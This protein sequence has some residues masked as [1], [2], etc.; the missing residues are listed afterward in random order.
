MNEG[1]RLAVYS[2]ILIGVSIVFQSQASK[3]AQPVLIATYALL[4][5]SVILLVMAKI[6]GKK[7]NAIN[8]LR[9][10]ADFWKITLSR[11]VFGTLLLLYGLSM[12]TSI[13]SLVILRLEPAFVIFFGYLLL[14]EKLKQKEIFYV[15]ATIIGAV[16]VSTSGVLSF[17][18]TQTGD[19]LVLSSLIFLGYSY[20]P[21]RRLMQKT[22]PL[23]LTAYSNLFGGIVLLIL[24]AALVK[25]LA[26]PANALLFTMVSVITFYVVG[27]SLWFEAL[28]K[29]QA[30][31]VASLLSI[32]PIAGGALSFL[33]L[34][35]SL[36][37]VQLTG[38]ITILLASYKLSAKRN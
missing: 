20:I 1:A 11:N 3:L 21:S 19:L 34:G 8:K 9:K 27:L 15:T 37:F 13:N 28:K 7:L 23:I 2:A 36:N 30:W 25:N 32:T 31:R 26:I 29:T 38:A 33:W 6:K 10:K 16:L 4:I 24:S 14:R 12:T 5:S 22:D 18:E 17:N 35:E